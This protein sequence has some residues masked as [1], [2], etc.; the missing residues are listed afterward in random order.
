MTIVCGPLQTGCPLGFRERAVDS[1]MPRNSSLPRCVSVTL[2]S[3]LALSECP[4]PQE[5]D[6]PM[7][8]EEATEEVR[9]IVVVARSLVLMM[10][11]C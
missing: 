6:T 8:V 3:T 10:V 11:C 9:M 7:Q 2:P 1:N 5:E 4:S